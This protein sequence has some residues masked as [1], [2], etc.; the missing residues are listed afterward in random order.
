MPLML[1]LAKIRRLFLD[2]SFSWEAKFRRPPLLFKHEKLC[3]KHG[4]TLEDDFG[5]GDV[6]GVDK[7]IWR[8]SH[9][10]SSAFVSWED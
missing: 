7:N 6:K 2:G 8:A 9:F 1:T 10:R 5:M 4:N 3:D